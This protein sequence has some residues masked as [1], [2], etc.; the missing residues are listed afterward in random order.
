MS[1]FLAYSSIAHTG[2]SLAAR[3]VGPN[4]L[5]L[6]VGAYWIS[7][8]AFLGYI[9]GDGPLYCLTGKNVRRPP[10]RVGIVVWLFSMGGIPPLAGF[11]AKMII[12]RTLFVDFPVL[13]IALIISAT[14]AVGYYLHVSWI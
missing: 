3:V 6:F 9:G 4:A 13:R 14:I 12:L 7:L 11:F 5:L 10:F 2:W 1:R 8:A